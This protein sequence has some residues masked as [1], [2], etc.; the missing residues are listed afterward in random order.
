MAYKISYKVAAEQAEQLKNIAKDMDNY[1]NQLNQIVG[2]LGND[3]LLQSVRNDLNKFKKQL[4]EEK[5]V[6]N[7][8]SSVISD[9]IQ[10]F[11]G[12]EKKS[13]G[14]VDK[15]K[16]HNRDFYKRPVAVASAGG[17]AAA[18]A[19]A[20][21]H[22]SVST[23]GGGSSVIQQQNISHSTTNFN[24]SGAS[25]SSGVSAAAPGV[26]TVSGL[27]GSLKDTLSSTVGAGVS[28]PVGLAAAGVLAAGGA[29][30]GAAILNDVS[31]EEKKEEKEE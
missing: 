8:A 15:A 21:S 4:E 31:K 14:K 30:A 23:G 27:G 12:V 6:L 22:V 18:G 10:S 5:T 13:V 29:V 20:A 3:E 19:A 26:S 16:A 28:A 11:S 17:G 1:V 24:F 25:G 9:V 7:L 2:K